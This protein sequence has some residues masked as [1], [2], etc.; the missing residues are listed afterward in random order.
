MTATAALV[1]VDR[2]HY[3]PLSTDSSWPGSI[4]CVSS[5]FLERSAGT[6]QTLLIHVGTPKRGSTKRIN[7][8]YARP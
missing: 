4:F 8:T 5:V 7:T 1:F 6:P 3:L 2:H